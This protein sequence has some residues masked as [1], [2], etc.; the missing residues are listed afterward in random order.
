MSDAIGHN[1]GLALLR[2]RQPLSYYRQRYG[3]PAWGLRR[4]YLLME[5]QHNRGQDGA[6]VAVVKFDM[7]PGV[8]YIKRVRSDKHNAIERVFD[9]V[10]DDVNALGDENLANLSDDELK[11]RCDF[12]GELY[13][14][15]LRYGTH[16]G[17]DLANCHPYLRTNNTASRNLVLAGNFNMTNAKELFDQLVEF[18]LNPVGDSD[19]QVILERISYCLDRE[20]N[21][22]RTT[23]GPESLRGLDGKDLARETSRQIDLIRILR[24]ASEDF[25]GGYVFAGL[26]GNGDAFACRDPAGIRPGFFYLNDEVV[27]VA[28]ERA[29]LANVFDVDPSDIEPIA[30]A[31]ALVVKRD[32]QIDH[33][34]F[35]RALALRQCTFERI[36]FSRGNDPAIH[37][38]RKALG[39]NL[40]PRVL[41]ALGDELGDAVFSYIPNTAEAAYVGLVEEIDRLTRTRRVEELWRRIERGTATRA[42]LERSLDGRLRTEK[43]AH[44]DQR[45]RTFIAHDAARRDLVGHIY[46][47]TRGVLKPNETLVIVDDSIVRGTTLRESIITMLS[48]LNPKR[49]II[50]SSAPPIK[51][52]DCYGIDMSQLGRF[53]AFEA[54]VAVLHDRG[55]EQLL[56]EVEQRCRAQAEYPQK[57]MVNQVAAI[58]DRVTLDELSA[59]VAQL[60]RSESLRWTGR[61]EIIYQTVQGLC[62][63]TPDH[64]GDWAFTG[65]YP[66]PG[67]Y[68]VLNTSYLNWRA[69][70]DVRAY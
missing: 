14:G 37:H 2:L 55:E 69:A 41:K 28:S 68:K 51:Y 48:R 32:G 60:V 13:L 17:N 61:V 38:E 9:I 67:G 65:D 5:K 43:V 16:S 63:A 1:C 22:L 26:L 33:R 53:I 29:A 56:D 31:H 66:T 7:P 27:A 59:K 18:G 21:Y 64:R 42:D 35:T 62:A 3:D 50:V 70:C 40:A 23:M 30:P 39:Y 36:Y 12:F 19:T 24:K 44:K 25:D 57:K 34:P 8:E 6:G 4:L 54:A 45:L 58:Y 11:R 52:P 20:H 15:H 49:I 10:M 46:D 47:I